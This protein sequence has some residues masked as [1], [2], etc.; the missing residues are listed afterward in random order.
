MSTKVIQNHIHKSFASTGVVENELAK[1]MLN[2]R[3]VSHVNKNV[4]I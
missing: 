3:H 4:E 2:D 1:G